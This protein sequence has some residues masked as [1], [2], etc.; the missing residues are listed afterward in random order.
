MRK[1]RILTAAAG[2]ATALVLAACGSGTTSGGGGGAGGGGATGAGGGGGGGSSSGDTIQI[3]TL[4]PLTGTYAGDGQQLENGVKLAI[5]AVNAAGGIKSLGGEKLALAQGDT[6][7]DPATGQSEAQRLIESGAV[8]LVGTYQSAVA[9]NVAAVAERNKTPFL[10][11]VASDTAILQQGYKYSFRIQPK[12]DLFAVQAAKYFKEL[13]AK[14]NPKITKI[15]Y[16]HESSSFGTGL[17][18]VFKKEA[19]AAGFQ[20][21]PEIS[22]DP[23]SVSDM[24]T[25]ITQVKAS[26][27]QALA[28]SGYYNDGVLIAKAIA[29]VQPKLEAVMGVADGA[30]DQAQFVAD[31]GKA[32]EN[33]FDV[34]YA[35]AKTAAAKQLASEYQST[36]G[37]PMRTEAALAYDAVRVIAAGLEKAKSTDR[38]KLRDAISQVS[39]EP[40]TAGTAIK[41]DAAGEN[42]GALP[43][44]EQV[45]NGKVVTVLPAEHASAKPIFPAVPGK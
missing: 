28:V 44:L 4:H 14:A 23:A 2:L 36:F 25:Q 30:F 20:V 22:Y 1:A 41:F 6:K 11:D 45:Q 18:Q 35:L 21:T 9:Q 42:T 12:A 34:N 40:T 15:A 19:E 29:A 5:K 10:M 31:V 26:G 13:N 27:A 16:L 3:G 8:A 33:Y 37:Q 24:T 38:T 43:V 32:S 7:G 17:Y 39:V